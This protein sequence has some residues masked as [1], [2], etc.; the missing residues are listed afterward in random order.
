MCILN[1][2][3]H[4]GDESDTQEKPEHGFL[5]L[6]AMI[7]VQRNICH[8]KTSLLGAPRGVRCA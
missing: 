8:R 2:A 5:Q 4:T 6:K 3:D 7:G 1:K